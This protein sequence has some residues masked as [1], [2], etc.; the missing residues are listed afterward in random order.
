MLYMLVAAVFS[1]FSVESFAIPKAAE[2][3][4]AQVTTGADVARPKRSVVPTKP[5]ATV[6]SKRGTKG[7][8]VN[9]AKSPK[10]AK[11]VRAK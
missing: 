1:F 10:K 8:H 3:E 6:K 11:S 2:H 9:A 4:D 7:K 5:P